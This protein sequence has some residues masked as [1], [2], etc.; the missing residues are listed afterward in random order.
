MQIISGSSNP[1]LASRISEALDVPLIDIE[2][3]RFSNDE[4]RVI[5]KAD[6]VDREVL[7]VQS[8]SQPTDHH[9]VEFTLICDA[10]KRMGVKEITAVVPW[11]GYSK[12]DKV[13]RQGEPL[14]VKVIAQILQ[15]ISLER[16]ITFDLHNLAI[17]GFFDIPVTNLT[18][19]K[20]FL[21]YYREHISDKT[22]VVAPDA[23]AVKSSTAFAQELGVP[24]AYVD[25]KR[26]L[27]TGAVSISGINRDVTD[28]HILV[29]D[30]MVVTGSTLIEV[31]DYLGEKGA[32]R[33][34]V[35]S[36]HHLY[37]NG[38]QDR[39]DASP[40]D[41]LVVTDTIMPKHS[42]A[43]IQILSVAQL[44]ANEIRRRG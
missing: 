34:E 31:S 14:S 12:Q 1:L 23:G 13:F 38:A 17:L 7:V 4:S 28:A 19:R 36:T 24:V 43:K 26:D 42:S 29:I 30:D 6:A 25:K 33:I 20:L 11:L 37:V 27:S 35:A 32:G 10:L 9:L 15:V 3:S 16:L 44:V 18:A 8:L 2:L 40:I 5:I 39:I 22:M 21:D 41:S